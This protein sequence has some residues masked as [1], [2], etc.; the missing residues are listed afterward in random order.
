MKPIDLARATGYSPQYIYELLKKE[1]RW[2]LDNMERVCESLDM[3]ID[4]YSVHRKI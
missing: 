3:K 4:V 2:N 1:K